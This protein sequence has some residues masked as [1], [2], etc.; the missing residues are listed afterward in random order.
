MI[1][2]LSN[3]RKQNTDNNKEKITDDN[4]NHDNA[5]SVNDD[6]GG[7]LIMITMTTYNHHDSPFFR[8]ASSGTV[9][10]VS[11]KFPPALKARPAPVHLGRLN[12]KQL[13]GS[14]NFILTKQG[15][16]NVCISEN[17]I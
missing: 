4:N 2:I 9:V 8:P 12:K 13:A 6:T 11:V 1:M 3:S 16:V 15:D 5:D 7:D 17:Y 14:F 10:L